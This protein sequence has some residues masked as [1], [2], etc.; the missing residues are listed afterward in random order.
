MK[1]NK[2]FL[3]VLTLLIVSSYL[4][5]GCIDNDMSKQYPNTVDVTVIDKFVDRG[6]W[7][8]IETDNGTYWTYWMDGDDIFDE[9][10]I[11][12]SYRL[13]IEDKPYKRRIIGYTLINNINDD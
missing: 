6:R 4:V 12:K 8:G 13:T 5:C 10:V 2:K 9:I 7:S 3:I 1:T 11:G